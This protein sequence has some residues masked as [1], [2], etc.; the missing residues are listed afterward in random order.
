[1]ERHHDLVQRIAACPGV[2][3]VE[4]GRS[5]EGQPMDC[6]RMGTGPKQV[7]LYARQHPGESMA[8]WWM[9]GALDWLTSRATRRSA[10]A[11]RPRST[12]SPT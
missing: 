11:T 8:E 9:E 7:W 2:A 10:C 12:S 6:L 3:L 1:M 4:L 5:L